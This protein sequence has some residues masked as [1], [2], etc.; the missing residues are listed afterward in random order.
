MVH[1]LDLGK[2]QVVAALDTARFAI[3]AME[4]QECPLC[5][6]SSFKTRRT[7]TTHVAR[8]MEEVALSSLPRD[9][10][11]EID[12]GEDSFSEGSSPVS[13]SLPH[14]VGHPDVLE[15]HPVYVRNAVLIGNDSIAQNWSPAELNVQ[16]RLVYV[17]S[18]WE[19]NTL[20]IEFRSLTPEVLRTYHTCISC[21]WWQE[22]EEYIITS[23]DLYRLL[24]SFLGTKFA[25]EGFNQFQRI[26]DDFR[27]LT[28]SE[29][30]GNREFFQLLVE[31][32]KPN[33]ARTGKI[34]EVFPWNILERVILE[35]IGKYVSPS[36]TLQHLTS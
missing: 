4:L 25:L 9:V 6:Q 15:P 2:T 19:K 1:K 22:K 20:C 23:V 11:S 16:R 34:V 12:D 33:V 10:E 36:G 29:A 18:Y 7:F 17:T 8:H 27:P 26:H 14:Y 31:F 35:V 13:S 5:H 3:D 21:I 32:S 28:V 30:K 24:E